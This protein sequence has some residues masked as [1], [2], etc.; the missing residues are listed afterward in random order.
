MDKE[1]IILSLI[2]LGLLFFSFFALPHSVF[3]IRTAW[4]EK[5]QKKMRKGVSLL[6]GGILTGCMFL[7]MFNG[8]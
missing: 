1:Y 7:K 4:E 8:I 5:D 6:W 3:A 2:R